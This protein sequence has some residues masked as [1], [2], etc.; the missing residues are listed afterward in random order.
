MK[1][2]VHTSRNRL[3][4]HRPGNHGSAFTLIEILVSVAVL[5]VLFVVVM[6]VSGYMFN[7]SHISS[8]QMDANQQ[9]RTVLD[10]LSSDINSA[11]TDY[12]QTFLVKQGAGNNTE[13]AFVI[14]DRGSASETDTRFI[15]VHYSLGADGGVVRRRAPITFGDTDYLAGIAQAVQSSASS[16]DVIA[17]SMLRMEVVL[18]LDNGQIVPLTESGS[19]LA[20]KVNGES[21]PSTLSG[22]SALA[23]KTFSIDPNNPRVLAFVIGVAALD[24]QGYYLPNAPGIADKLL[25]PPAGQTPFDCWN[26]VINSS[27]LASFPLPSVWA[28]RL[29][30]T[31]VYVKK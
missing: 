13:M 22:F 31:T 5:A 29:L 25:T 4:F 3:R 15:A 30:Q 20:D 6:Q 19:W 18:I 27:Q 23:L 11:V 26:S 8:V 14:R 10:V 7:A 16:S 17:G 9:A 28:L 21:L 24:A 2:L 12:G 1:T